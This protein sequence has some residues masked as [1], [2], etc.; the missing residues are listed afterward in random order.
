MRRN[1]DLT[2]AALLAE[3]VEL[4]LAERV[5]RSAARELVAAAVS[6]DSFRDGLAQHVDPVELDELLEPSTYAGAADVFVDRALA[7]ARQELGG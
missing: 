3:R 4:R 2:G 7:F 6:A 1:L 5:G